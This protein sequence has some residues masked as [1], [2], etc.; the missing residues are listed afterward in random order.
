LAAALV[1]LFAVTPVFAAG[2]SYSW[3][4]IPLTNQPSARLNAVM[5]YDPAAKNIVLFGGDDGVS[6][7]NDTW[8]FNSS[9]WV[10]LHPPVSPPVRTAAAMGFDHQMNKLVMFGGFNGR[11]YLGDTWVWD[12]VAQTW[13]EQNP[14]ILPTP[15]TLPMLYT[16]P[17]TGHAGM[18]G[19]Y[20]GNFYQNITWQWTGTDWKFRNP[21]TWLWA[22]GSAVVANDYA[23]GK[24]VIFG[25]LADVN[26][27]N[28]WTW[29][30]VN[31]TMENPTTQPPW[32]YYTPG[33]Y[34]PMVGGVVMFGGSSGLN[35][36]WVWTGSNWIHLATTN[37]PP[38]R[39]SHGLAYDYNLNRLVMFGGESSGNLV[40]TT[41]E[42]I[43][44]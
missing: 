40:D 36:T 3:K 29:D 42:M 25:G 11:N 2:S 21:V 6:Y 19:G 37:S 41:L 30:G 38:S 26:P 33:A 18:V 28:T 31:W 32:S 7:L 8:I 44:Q 20:D 35:F 39:D 22:R 15:V 14:T 13:T 12:G 1:S 16:D 10:Q 17:V 24:V 43:V 34:D 4:A 5:A 9:G 23:H 27:V